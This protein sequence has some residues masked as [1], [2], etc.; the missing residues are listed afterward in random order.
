MIRFKLERY[1]ILEHQEN[2]SSEQFENITLQVFDILGKMVYQQKG[3]VDKM[4]KF[5]QDFKP[6]IYVV[7]VI[8]SDKFITTKI[9]K[10]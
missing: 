4:Y 8:Q 1:S 5:G 2:I 7:K 9:I 3:Q 10:Q 6:G